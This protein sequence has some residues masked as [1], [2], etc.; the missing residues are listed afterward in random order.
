MVTPVNFSRAVDTCYLQVD[1]LTDAVALLKQ[2]FVENR[3]W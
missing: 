2:Q 3:V 1:Q